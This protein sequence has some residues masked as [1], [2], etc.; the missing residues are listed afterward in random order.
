[1]ANGK[2]RGWAP[3]RA[4]TPQAGELARFLRQ[5]ID[6][7]GFTLRRLGGAV[8][9]GKST[10]SDNLSGRVPPLAFVEAVVTAVVA[11]PRKRGMDLERAR[12]LWRAADKPPAPAA[13]AQTAAQPSAS[14]VAVIK[15]T[16]DTL[17]V[18]YDRNVAL[19]REKATSHQLVLLLVRLVAALNDKVEQLSAIPD[20]AAEL[21]AVN[22]QL[23]QARQELERARQARQDAEAL[24]ARAQRQTV[25]LQEELAQLR[26][27]APSATASAPANAPTELPPELHEDF[28]LADVNRALRTAEGFLQEGAQQRERLAEDIGPLTPDPVQ[29]NQSW[30]ALALVLGRTL[31]CVLMM[32]GSGVHYAVSTWAT[33]SQ[34]ALGFTELPVLAGIALLVDPWDI[35]GDTLWPM[36]QRIT[37]DGPYEPI[38]WNLTAAEVLTRVLRVPWAAAAS[39]A[40]VLGVATVYWWSAWI[41]AATVPAAFATM[42]YAVLGRNKP[43]VSI[44]APIFTGIGALVRQALPAADAR[45][46]GHSGIRKP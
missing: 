12:A 36:L 20:T 15:T 38:V 44:V 9:Y 4:Q 46:A 41:L 21:A 14:T 8:P 17:A 16:S 7:H 1:M 45:T 30:R 29:V 43:V 11:E 2:G 35:I 3:L 24:A 22:E 6:H 13:T 28:F 23:H 10:I 39:T 40:T 25:S 42:G 5:L 31:G 26:A 33:T 32:V 18:V 19:E 27:A 37:G 34:T